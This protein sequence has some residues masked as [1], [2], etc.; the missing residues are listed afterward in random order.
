MNP[1]I[2]LY[3]EPT[4]GPRQRD[5]LASAGPSSCA[6]WLPVGMTIDGGDP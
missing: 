4:I 5:G 1:D 6:S 2:M 3:D